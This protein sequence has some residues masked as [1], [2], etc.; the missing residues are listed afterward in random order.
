MMRA[1]NRPK[2]V[3]AKIIGNNGCYFL[4]IINGAERYMRHKGNPVSVDIIN[5]Y[6]K[7]ADEG[8]IGKDCYIQRPDCIVAEILGVSPDRVK[9][10]KMPLNYV[11][12]EDEIEIT[13]YEKEGTGVTFSHFVETR[14][15][16]VLYDPYG[17]SSTVTNG[18]PVSKRIIKVM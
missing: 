7:A 13:R 10:S 9:V 2:Q 11:P 17:S 14:N 6:E 18:V 3:E 15:G 1:M 16:E 12:A 4:A 5:L 8:W